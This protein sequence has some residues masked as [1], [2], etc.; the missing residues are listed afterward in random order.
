MQ[1][2]L[3]VLL[4]VYMLIRHVSFQFDSLVSVVA[5]EFSSVLD[6]QEQFSP[7]NI[8][9]FRRYNVKPKE[10]GYIKILGNF[11]QVPRFCLNLV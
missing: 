11:S 8:C 6:K 3:H 9:D 10:N 5:L 7:P 1:N 4:V 2:H